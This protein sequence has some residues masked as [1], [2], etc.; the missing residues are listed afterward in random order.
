[1]QNSTPSETNGSANII[2]SE[3]IA[4]GAETNTD[5]PNGRTSATKVKLPKKKTSK[6]WDHYTEIF[7]EETV[8][9]MVTKKPMAACKY[10]VDVLCASSKQGTTRLWNHY[11]AFHDEKDKKTRVK[12]CSNVDIYDEETSVRKYY[13]AIIMHEYPFNFCEHE[14][15]NDFIRSLR[16][17]FPIK[18]RKTARTRIMEIFH[19]EKNRLFDYFSSLNCQFS[20]TMDV[21]TSN[22]NKGYLCVTCHFIDDE[23]KIHKRIINFMHLEGRHTGANLSAAFMQNIASWNIDHKLFALTLDN[24]SAND[25]CVDTV[26]SI[27]KNVGTV[28]CGGKF[29][30]VRCAAHIINLIARD[31]VSTISTVIANVRALVLIVKS[32]PLQEEIFFKHVADMGIA[33]RGLSLD[34]STRWNSTYLMLADALHYKRVFQRLILLNPDKYGSHAPSREEWKNATTL[35]NCLEIF[36]DA[37]KILSGN[38]YPTSNLFFSEFCEINLKIIEWLNSNVSG[39]IIRGTLKTPNSQLVTPISI[40]LQRPDGHD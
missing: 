12:K 6:V 4:A 23:W 39:T 2:E 11:Y 3:T 9:G 20:C 32:S 18:G 16:P 1:L 15:T 14:Y 25:V 29:F 7:V 27:L 21:W 28:H 30:H 35:C 19:N 17:N 8:D 22:Q 40:K 26:I 33:E 37:T 36:Y 34:V 10:C 24:A 5:S 38:H 31:G 13:L